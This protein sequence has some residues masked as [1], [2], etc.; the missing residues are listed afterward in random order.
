MDNDWLDSGY[1][2]ELFR[3]IG[4]TADDFIGLRG[5]AESEFSDR[6]VVWCNEG[7]SGPS[8]AVGAPNLYNRRLGGDGITVYYFNKVSPRIAT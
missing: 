2:R 7:L 4:L 6:I 8:K 1:S 3:Q 5:I